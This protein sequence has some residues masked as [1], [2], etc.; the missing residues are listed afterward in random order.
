MSKGNTGRRRKDKEILF[1]IQPSLMNLDYKEDF[2]IGNKNESER[3]LKEGKEMIKMDNELDGVRRSSI[4]R[5]E[6]KIKQRK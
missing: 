2:F 1:Y 3:N 4:H 5:K 6:K